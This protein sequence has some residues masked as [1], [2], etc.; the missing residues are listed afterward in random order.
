VKNVVKA[1]ALINTISPNNVTYKDL[2]K[3]LEVIYHSR[4]EH[5]EKY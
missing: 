5:I 1:A 2:L 3:N 4:T